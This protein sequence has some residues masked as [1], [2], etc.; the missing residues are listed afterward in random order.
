MN[1]LF[2]PS[3][4]AVR[5]L[6]L[7]LAVSL[8]GCETMGP[9]SGLGG[10]PQVPLSPAEQQ[11]RDDEKRFNDTVISAVLLGAA[12]GAAVGGLGCLIAGCKGRDTVKA[13]G[14][15]AVVGGA[16]LG[17]D[18]YVTAKKEQAGK[19]NLRAVQAAANDV[20]QD[21]N[22]LQAYLA[23]S[24]KVLAEGQTRLASLQK[25]LAAKRIG[26][27]EAQQAREREERNVASMN[28]TLAQA[29]KTRDQYIEAST[30]M[31]DT[32]QNKRDLDG[33]IRR[34]NQQIATLESH[35]LA[36]NQALAVSRA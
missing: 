30:K 24:S 16:A 21:N 13:A 35:V 7:A 18:G 25:D 28:Q 5:A 1:T 33:E 29:R 2:H 36:Y 11:M 6:V 22:K 8:A 14:I 4:T 31:P 23:S 17:I 10:G 34:M 9:L 20:R 15:G 32:P 19:Q 27:A 26:T 3:R 12:G